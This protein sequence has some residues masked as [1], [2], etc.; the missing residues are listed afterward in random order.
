MQPKKVLFTRVAALAVVCVAV[1]AFI[2]LQRI[3]LP[4]AIRAG[5]GRADHSALPKLQMAFFSVGQG[6]AMLLRDAAGNDVLIDGGPTDAILTKLGRTM[7]LWDRTIELIVLTHPH[8]DHVNGLVSVLE[9]YHADAIAMTGVRADTSAYAAFSRLIDEKKIPVHIIT[10][11]T[12][13]SVGLM[14][15][16]ILWPLESWHTRAPPTDT[17]STG[18]GLNDTSIVLA[19]GYGD[20]RAL[21]MEDA[22]AAVEARLLSASSTLA[23]DLLKVGHHGS[24]YSSSRAFLDAVRPAYAVIPVGARNRYGHPTLQTLLRLR[25]VQAKIFRTDRDGDVRVVTDGRAIGV[26]G[27]CGEEPCAA[28]SDGL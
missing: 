28:A 25:D 3:R 15:L 12:I 5:A 10:T 21:F 18:G 11:S 19:L 23:A 2:F 16:E 7:P 13:L 4:T 8:A 1:V 20:V 6:D 17:L 24:M 27:A 22:S 14:R 9:R 26:M